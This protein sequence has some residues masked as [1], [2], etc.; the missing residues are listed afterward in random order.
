MMAN[1]IWYSLLF[2]AALNKHQNFIFK[3]ILYVW[4][5][6]R[7][8]DTLWCLLERVSLLSSFPSQVPISRFWLVGDHPKYHAK[9]AFATSSV[10]KGTKFRIKNN[11]S[12]N[13]S[14]LRGVR[15][16]LLC[17]VFNF[18][19]IFFLYSSMLLVSEK[20]HYHLFSSN[21]LIG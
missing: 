9:A 12:T 16:S 19:K 5:L 18:V 1:E 4:S 17:W 14:F 10:E 11:Q 2:I 20:H 7:K 3:R 8:E 6:F 13:C 15:H 21:V